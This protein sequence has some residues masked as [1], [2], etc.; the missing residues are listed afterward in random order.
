M[1]HVKAYYCQIGAIA[2]QIEQALLVIA[3]VLNLPLTHHL[4]RQ[5]SCSQCCFKFP[6]RGKV[7]IILPLTQ[8]TNDRRSARK[9]SS[10]VGLVTQPCSISVMVFLNEG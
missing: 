10:Q 9:K 6:Q 5:T 4:Q 7:I 1:P 8:R 3:V 2:V